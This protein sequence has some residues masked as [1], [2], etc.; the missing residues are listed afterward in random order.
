MSGYPARILASCSVDSTVRLWDFV[1]KKELSV[2]C[3]HTKEVMCVAYSDF[4]ELLISGGADPMLLVWNLDCGQPLQRIYVENPDSIII[5]IQTIPGTPELITCDAKGVFCI[6]DLRDLSLVQRFS[7]SVQISHS[8]SAVSC[9]LDQRILFAACSDRGIIRFDKLQ[10]MHHDKKFVEASMRQQQDLARAKTLA[11]TRGPVGRLTSTSKYAAELQMITDAS[12]KAGAEMKIRLNRAQKEGAS[13]SEIES[14][15]VLPPRMTTKADSKRIKLKEQLTDDKRMPVIW[16]TYNPVTV[17]VV[18][19]SNSNLLVWD[20]LTG[21]VTL[22][23]RDIMEGLISSATLDFRARRIFI[24]DN[25]GEIKCFDLSTGAFM[26]DFSAHE[27]EVSVL[28]YSLSRSEILSGSWDGSTRFHED[29]TQSDAAAHF[30]SGK[31]HQ[32]DVTALVCSD[33]FDLYAS[34]SLDCSVFVFDPPCLNVSTIE[35]LGSIT[36][37]TFLG[38]LPFL[39]VADSFGEITIFRT[40]NATDCTCVV[41]FFN[42]K[43]TNSLSK[44]STVVSEVSSISTSTRNLVI[45]TDTEKWDSEP[46]TAGR[47]PHSKD[48]VGVSTLFFDPTSLTLYSG[49]E[50]GYVNAWNL[51]EA[52]D[53]VG[54][55]VVFE[56][57][58]AALSSPDSLFRSNRF[59]P[60]SPAAS[61]PVRVTSSAVTAL[62]PL[63]LSSLDSTVPAPVDQRSDQLDVVEQAQQSMAFSDLSTSVLDG[64]G[65]PLGAE[66][67]LNPFQP[68]IKSYDSRV[69][70]PALEEF[71]SKPSA[72]NLADSSDGDLQNLNQIQASESHA[73]QDASSIGT[74]PKARVVMFPNLKIVSNVTFKAHKSKVTGI[75]MIDDSDPRS[76]LTFGFDGGIHTWTLTGQYLAS[77]QGT[78]NIS[79]EHIDLN[80]KSTVNVASDEASSHDQSKESRVSSN[81]SLPLNPIV[82]QS[83]AMA[84]I[85]QVQQL[86]QE[87]TV[88]NFSVQSNASVTP[89]SNQ[90]NSLNQPL[91]VPP[92][93]LSSDELHSE[94]FHLQNSV[95]T[96]VSPDS[97]SESIRT[98][99]SKPSKSPKN[100]PSGKI[101]TQPLASSFLSTVLTRSA[102]MSLVG[103]STGEFHLPPLVQT[104]SSIVLASSP[105]STKA[106]AHIE[107]E[108]SDTAALTRS[109]KS[110]KNIRSPLPPISPSSASVN[111]PTHSHFSVDRNGGT[112]KAE[113]L[114]KQAWNRG[115][116]KRSDIFY[117]TNPEAFLA[118][119]EGVAVISSSTYDPLVELP[120][121]ETQRQSLGR[122]NSVL[123]SVAVPHEAD[124]ASVGKE[125]VVSPVY[126]RPTAVSVY[127]VRPVPGLPVSPFL[128]PTQSA[129]R[130][131]YHAVNNIGSPTRD[132]GVNPPPVDWNQVC[133]PTQSNR[134][135]V[136]AHSLHRAPS[137][138][139]FIS[140]ESPSKSSSDSPQA[141]VSQS[142]VVPSEDLHSNSD[143]V[144]PQSSQITIDEDDHD[145]EHAEAPVSS[146]VLQTSSPP[147]SGSESQSESESKVLPVSL[148]SKLL[149]ASALT[150]SFVLAKPRNSVA[151][152]PQA[153]Q[154]NSGS[155]PVQDSAVTWSAADHSRYVDAENARRCFSNGLMQ[156]ATFITRTSDGKLDVAAL[157]RNLEAALAE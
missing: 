1:G 68:Q 25:R 4:S 97:A 123:Q 6:Y 147:S 120:L 37:L 140:S 155:I 24:G 45:D 75:K 35:C 113:K 69:I 102:S 28:A 33:A 136:G 43:S 61:K 139:T 22:A 103:S 66:I 18:A 152:S 80:P 92:S 105:G 10:A 114:A 132:I 128:S 125:A 17:S 67:E 93:L 50:Q 13:Q 63:E 36:A 51:T 151:N 84:E 23:V 31:L 30:R 131:P 27:K 138:K 115:T 52:L 94:L 8:V 40:Y 85:S 55:A 21:V 153:A 88:S 119:S 124:A 116:V 46:N 3:G 146:V 129:Q 141:A 130:R 156:S 143:M 38:D 73:A 154:S 144:S 135:G 5:S 76:L 54:K 145:A 87:R 148:E 7:Q 12:V 48:W 58:A 99:S 39:A 109:S 44:S 82:H 47:F 121:T 126:S 133:Q 70:N 134:K 19:V 57:P 53:A 78:T 90:S 71:F 142:I 137:L 41:Q 104:S 100:S 111:S 89:P 60:G 42:T 15:S 81:W 11:S 107:A 65:G 110:M 108:W 112:V 118:S 32:R 14:L 56:K 16:C 20:A 62:P 34:G 96:S 150:R 101:V 91:A 59:S 79:D 2:L 9:I 83:R 149:A 106:K 122:L 95:P 117:R 64:S 86:L 26:R 29:I 72:R 77:M 127:G 49:D 98:T 157:S 74:Q